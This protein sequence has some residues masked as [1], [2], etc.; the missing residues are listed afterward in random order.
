M[1]KVKDDK[2]G[3]WKPIE[4]FIERDSF[5]INPMVI[6]RGENNCTLITVSVDIDYDQDLL[7]RVTHG[8]DDVIKNCLQDNLKKYGT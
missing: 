1:V 4:G 2:T 3:E 5:F 7:F 6:Q 8:L